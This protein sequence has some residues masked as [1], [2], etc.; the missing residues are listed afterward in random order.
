MDS[1]DACWH[2]DVGFTYLKNEHEGLDR[3]LEDVIAVETQISRID[4]VED[5]D[6]RVV[7]EYVVIHS[8]NE[9]DM[10]DKTFACAITEDLRRFIEVI[11]PVVDTFETEQNRVDN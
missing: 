8:S 6:G 1:D 7:E 9:G 4:K 11:S 2:A 10:L 3:C 5:E